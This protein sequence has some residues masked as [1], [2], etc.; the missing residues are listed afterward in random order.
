MERGGA[1]TTSRITA[2]IKQHTGAGDAATTLTGKTVADLDFE[3]FKKEFPELM[4]QSWNKA[5]QP[6]LHKWFNDPKNAGYKQKVILQIKQKLRNYMV[7]NWVDKQHKGAG[8][9]PTFGLVPSA[10][11]RFGIDNPDLF[12]K[13]ILMEPRPRKDVP[14]AVKKVYKEGGTFRT[15][16]SEE[17]AKEIRI[18]TWTND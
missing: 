5:A 18:L 11:E 14:E 9:R 2:E 6:L 3:S 1:T 12:Q 4:N 7:I 8:R 16:N 13:Y 15:Q 10:A 17:R